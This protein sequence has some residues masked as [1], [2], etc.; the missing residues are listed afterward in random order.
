MIR[1]I[2]SH[3]FSCAI[4]ILAEDDRPQALRDERGDHVRQGAGDTDRPF[5]GLDADEVLFEAEMVGIDL[6]ATLEVVAHA[7]FGVDV[8]RP[9]QPF[10]PERA[11]GGHGAGQAQDADGG[12]L[13]ANGLQCGR[14]TI[15][16]NS[17]TLASRPLAAKRG[18]QVRVVLGRSLLLVSARAG[19]GYH[20]RA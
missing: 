8:D 20:D 6:G 2:W 7:V 3:S 15:A 18:R 11:F 14:R 13:H 9:D 4:G 12:D 1:C 17:W 5:I 19:R 10:L 16:S